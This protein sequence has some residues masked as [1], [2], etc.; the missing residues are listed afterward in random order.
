ML[1]IVY[2]HNFYNDDFYIDNFYNDDFHNKG[3]IYL[4][5]RIY[6]VF[7]VTMTIFTMPNVYNNGWHSGGVYID[8]SSN[9]V[10]IVIGEIMK[11]V[12]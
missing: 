5:R 7:F 8:E 9:I 11:L 3:R 4:L 2:H 1:T 12:G 6:I 10:N